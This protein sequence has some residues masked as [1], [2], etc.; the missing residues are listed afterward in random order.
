MVL[1]LQEK[2]VELRRI[3]I[4][5]NL[6]KLFSRGHILELL[7]HHISVSKRYGN[8]LAVLMLDIDFFKKINDTFGH[9]TGDEVLARVAGVLNGQ[10][11]ETDLAGRYGGEEFLI[12]LTNQDIR[13]AETTAERLRKNIE[14]LQWEKEGLHVTI[15]GGIGILSEDM[16]SS[17]KIIAEADSNLYRSKETGRN[18]ITG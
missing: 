17:K 16:D 6:T 14:E 4:Y 9:Q 10:I 5:D 13:G 7:E 2:T 11:R 1:Q 18:R 15:S 8:N 12:I 3:A